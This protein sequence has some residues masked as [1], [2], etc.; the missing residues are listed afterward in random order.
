[1]DISETV[2]RWIED[3]VS[4]LRHKPENAATVG[5]MVDRFIR[6]ARVA[7]LSDLKPAKLVGWLAAETRRGVAPRTVRNELAAVRQWSRY[8][9][10]YELIETPPFETV[11][12][13]RCDT[14]DG[15]DAISEEQVEQLI[16]NAREE[17]H[18]ERWQVRSNAPARLVAYLLMVEVGLRIG[19]VRGQRWEDVDLR[20][21][22]MRISTDKAKRRDLVAL[23]KRVRAALRWLRWRQQL[24]GD[25]P[26]RVVPRG[27]NA[28]KMRLDL[29]R[30]GCSGEMG[31][32][33]RLRKYAI[34]TRAMS[35]WDMWR[36]VRF[37]RHRDPK[38]TLRYVRPANEM[39]ETSIPR[40]ARV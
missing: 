7:D 35:G 33:H 28:K 39:R 30:V 36:L 40:L 9:V 24:D 12:V 22:T 1:M 38:T 4:R 34:T 25:L 6:E 2:E 16:R 17:L 15:C 14:D 20:E 26:D 27:P 19:E 18:A 37:A 10:T 13:A 21:E 32:F 3:S 29:D 11:K 31:R 5:R 23:P 8:L